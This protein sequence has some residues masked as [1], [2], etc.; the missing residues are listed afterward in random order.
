MA[1]GGKRSFLDS[2]PGWSG[3]RDR[4]RRRESDRLLRERLARD[5]GEV[6]DDLGRLAA[7][8]AEDRKLRAIRYVDGPHGRLTHFTD[9]LK[10]ATYGYAGLFSERPVDADALD[11]IAAFDESLGDGVERIADAT[12]ALRKT[13]PD[14]EAFRERSEELGELIENLLDRLDRRSELI[15]SGAARPEAEIDAL[16]ATTASPAIEPTAYP[17]SRWR[18]RLLSECQLHCRGSHHG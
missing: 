12:E 3:Y 10:T 2:I 11:Q 5:Y 8:L 9:R 1:D 13:D 4:E 14:D 18:R 16:L 15:E 17:P 6:A 7:R